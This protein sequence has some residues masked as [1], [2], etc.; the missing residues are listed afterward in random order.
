MQSKSTGNDSSAVKALGVVAGSLPLAEGAGKKK[1]K[2]R[3]A[4]KKKGEKKKS[5]PGDQQQLVGGG[6]Q[7]SSTFL[8][9]N[10]QILPSALLQL[11]TSKNKI[12]EAL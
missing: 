4:G 8:D 2:T 12:S 3:R 1:G 9:L 10:R 11:I 7:N 5:V 6:T